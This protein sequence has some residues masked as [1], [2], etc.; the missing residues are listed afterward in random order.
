VLCVCFLFFSVLF[1]TENIST[2]AALCVAVRV[3][4]SCVWG[5]S[6]LRKGVDKLLRLGVVI[7]ML[8]GKAACLAL[9]CGNVE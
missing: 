3:L 4:F 9:Q 7:K 6:L 8:L 1:F 5:L 2:R